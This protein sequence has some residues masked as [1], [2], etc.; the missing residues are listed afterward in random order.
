L[1]KQHIL[2]M[3][4]SEAEDNLKQLNS[5]LVELKSL[6]ESKESHMQ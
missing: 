3:K 5:Q 2:E 1:E 6:V 4:G